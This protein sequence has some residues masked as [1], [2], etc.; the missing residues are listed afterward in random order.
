MQGG[1][2]FGPNEFLTS[3]NLKS[4]QIG[5]LSPSNSQP[6]SPRSSTPSSPLVRN[7]DFAITID[8][9]KINMLEQN[10]R[11]FEGFL[12]R[13]NVLPQAENVIGTLRDML[14]SNKRGLKMLR[15]LSM[16]VKSHEP[17]MDAPPID[18]QCDPYS[19]LS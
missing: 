4:I 8:F 18:N 17:L 11:D 16:I 6:N 1:Q 12:N 7:H 19:N 9:E 5:G 2:S 3:H 14:I 15:A 10:L 13:E